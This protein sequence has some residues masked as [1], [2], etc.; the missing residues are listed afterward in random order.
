MGP[1]LVVIAGL[2][3]YVV[4][5]K[6]WCMILARS[7]RAASRPAPT[8]GRAFVPSPLGAFTGWRCCLRE[9]WWLG[10][11][12]VPSSARPEGGGDGAQLELS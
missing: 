1:V 9:Q 5:S 4:G 8:L 6:A 7:S 10:V 3:R 12:C 2:Y 11:S